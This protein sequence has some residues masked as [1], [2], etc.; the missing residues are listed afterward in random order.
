[1]QSEMASASIH[2]PVGSVPLPPCYSDTGSLFGS[3]AGINSVGFC[4]CGVVLHYP[5]GDHFRYALIM[6]CKSCCAIHPFWHWGHLT[7]QWQV[8]GAAMQWGGWLAFLGLFLTMGTSYCNI[9]QAFHVI[10]GCLWLGSEGRFGLS[11]F[12]VKLRDAFC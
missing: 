12:C 8:L 3:P 10:D 11:F 7:I 1:M 9:L 4:P 5:S 6:L 2:S